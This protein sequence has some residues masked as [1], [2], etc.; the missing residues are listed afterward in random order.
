MD[1]KVCRSMQKVL[2][3]PAV[4]LLLFGP[5]A[6][7]DVGLP[8]GIRMPPDTS[9]AV[10][11]Q[12]FSGRFLVHV[13]RAGTLDQFQFSGEGWRVVAFTPPKAPA[14]VQP[15]M[16]EIPFRAIPTDASKRIGLSLTYNGQTVHRAYDVGRSVFE[17][18]GKRY[19][20]HRL[21]DDDRQEV[22]PVAPTLDGKDTDQSPS[23][24]A[25][26]RSQSI[27]VTGRIVYTR[28]CR[29]LTGDG[30]CDDPEDMPE[31]MIG[32]D[33]LDVRLLDNDTVGSEEMW[34]GYTDVNGYFDT[35][36][37]TWEGSDFDP[38][39]DL[40][41]YAET[42][43]AHVVDVTDDS[44]GEY[45]YSFD[46]PEVT[47]FTGSA[48]NFGTLTP[49]DSGMYPA[50]HIFNSISRA[51]RYVTDVP[52]HDLPKV[53]VMWP[54][55]SRVGGAWY[56]RNWNPPEIHLST[57]RQWQEGTHTH[58]YG[59]HYI[60]SLYASEFPEP[61]YCNDGTAYC[62][63]A[64]GVPG[65]YGSDAERCG[66]CEW[67]QE[68]DHDAFG[69]G[70]PNWLADVVT[71]DYP[72]RYTFDDGTAFTALFGRSEEEIGVCC[73][74]GQPHNPFLTEGFVGALLRDIEDETQD[75][76]D[77]DGIMDSLCTGPTPIFDVVDNDQ[78]ITISDF[79]S[80]FRASFPEYVDDLY[81]TAFNV[82]PQYVAG[83]P[84][85]TRPP[86]PIAYV[87]SPT[88]PYLTGGTSPC[89]T[90]EWLP[91]NDDRGACFYAYDWAPTSAGT[92]PSST[93]HFVLTDG[94]YLQDEE[95]YG[96]GQWW[97]SIKAQDCPDE[98]GSPGSWGPT[99]TFGPFEVTD[100]NGSGALDLCD[101]RC[102][103]EGC[104]AGP[105]DCLITENWCPPGSCETSEDCNGNYA[106]DE[107]D[108]A[109]GTSRDC[110]R[111]AIPDECENMFHWDGTSGSWHAG[112]NWLEGTAPSTNSAVCINVP[113]DQTVTYSTD[114][115]QIASLACSENLDIAGESFPWANLTLSEA[116]WVDG[117]LELSGDHTVLRVEDRLD[118]EGRLNWTGSIYHS[119]PAGLEGPGVTYA[120][121]GVQIVDIVRMDGH[122]VLDGNS[123]S[124][125]TT[126]ELYSLGN[127]AVFE[128]RPGSTYEYQGSG[129]ILS[130]FTNDMF[131]NDGTLIKS[132]DSGESVLSFPTDN[133]GLIHV[134]DGTLVLDRPCNSTGNFLGDPGTTID[135][136][137]GVREFFPSS[138]IVADNVKFTRDTLVRG[139]YN[140][141]TATTHEIDSL[142]FTDEAN[143]I[144][145]GSS[146]YIL[147][148]TVNFDA[149]V[150]G[151]IQF[152]TLS[153][154]TGFGTASFNSGDPVQVSNLIIAPGTVQGP[155]T[156][157]VTTLLTWGGS[158][159]ESRFIGPGVVN[160]NGDTTIE[161]GGSTKRLDNRVLNNAGTATFLHRLRLDG[162]AAFNN[163][164]SG[165]MDIQVDGEL[166][167]GSLNNAGTMVK[168]AGT[169]TSEVR[170][171]ANNTGTVEVQAGVLRL[172]TRYGSYYVQTAG[173][174]VLN[175]GDLAFTNY[176]EPFD[177]QG[178]LLTGEGTITG[179]VA[180]AGGTTAPGLSA[181]VLDIV[182]NYTQAAG[183][184]LEIE[185]GGVNQGSE[186]DLLT[187]SGAADLAGSLE[188]ILPDSGFVP[189][190]GDSFQ[191]L[192]A[193]SVSG[194]FN[195]VNVTNLSPYL[196]VNVI[197]TAT[198]VTLNMVGVVPGDC[199][200]DGDADLDD[201]ALLEA[202]L[203]GPGGGLGTGCGCFDM[204]A[205]V[206]VDLADVAAFTDRFAE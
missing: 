36:V 123:T 109:D 86:D 102:C 33:G 120:N 130:G 41:I 165:V 84:A 2:G 12:E 106:P 53:Q 62:D 6:W 145:Y 44:V 26:G 104:T 171:A 181:G 117:D 129:H 122:L 42:E 119:Y 45:T 59:H 163:L 10:A 19:G 126:G 150:G 118:I 196:I 205:D 178:G 203:L 197:Y 194:Q 121:G 89:I 78:P 131:D 31:R 190:P 88:H 151:T 52:V 124:I 176:G 73:Q 54:D 182:G 72:A 55:D 198:D 18:A 50:L 83:F 25:G 154:E 68:T 98:D 146:F 152:D 16:I 179:D 5:I 96:L 22:G 142:T 107:C 70:F 134:Q 29:D 170:A 201:Y 37:F 177:F 90:V 94:C 153:L 47:D 147:S 7:A 34:S 13:F 28:P 43:V 20:L 93:P 80:G 82:S 46:T 141:T 155:S 186:Y 99:A 9:Q 97:F 69:E 160:L 100:C 143:I 113:E 168:S 172:H 35:G 108:I 132:V 14:R 133:S 3:L 148:G 81:P 101:I 103:D 206:D 27:H 79:I 166:I 51:H 114:S 138:S 15:G 23:D 116:S 71:R 125:T 127:S 1:M 202:C 105:D 61:D 185:I 65:C 200:L 195:P 95:R 204:N 139:T 140:V 49:A 161:A 149:I 110:N 173:Q 183:G 87:S 157:T 91:A 164:P 128:I 193:G 112:I 136:R 175:G 11:G 75:D 17:R 180:N 135:F 199:D 137:N 184:T 76:H 4:V 192:T 159:A 144:S 58:E 8:I 67:C 167:D 48:Y 24:E 187:V 158:Y 191:I 63:Y 85:D 74:D 56:E 169:G 60:H 77:T 57:S 40:V 30:D 115:L 111:N 38:D 156:V 189:A 162:S 64:S 21:D 174:T 66:H 39:P 188:V 32:V 92:E